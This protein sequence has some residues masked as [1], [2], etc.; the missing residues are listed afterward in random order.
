[1]SHQS[2]AETVIFWRAH[3][4]QSLHP[5]RAKWVYVVT[6]PNRTNRLSHL[7][8]TVDMFIFSDFLKYRAIDMAEVAVQRSNSPDGRITKAKKYAVV[9]VLRHSIVSCDASH[10]IYI[11]IIIF[12]AF[13]TNS[14]GSPPKVCCVDWWRQMNIL[15]I[16]YA[17]EQINVCR[18]L[19][20]V[21]LIAVYATACT[22]IAQ[23]MARNIRGVKY[24]CTSN[25][26]SWREIINLKWNITEY[27]SIN[28]SSQH[29]QPKLKH[30][31]SSSPE[32]RPHIVHVIKRSTIFRL[33]ALRL[34]NTAHQ[35]HR[36]IVI[37]LLDDSNKRPTVEVAA[38]N[39]YSKD[40][41]LKLKPSKM[42]PRDWG[43]CAR[44]PHHRH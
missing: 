35:S 41:F 34:E 30:F 25:S 23:W 19:T 5:I 28:G 10:S 24:S 29:Q 4:V 11:V 26:L 20:K 37:L 44:W 27:D 42:R 21:C 2:G 40:E 9:F 39:V 17:C 12:I 36:I 3:F 7:W 6:E 31:C 14:F 13:Q 38:M 16:I 1:M 22:V 43:W 33:V 8:Q 15:F 18:R 32:R